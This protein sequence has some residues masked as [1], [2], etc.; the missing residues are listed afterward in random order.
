MVLPENA[1]WERLCFSALRRHQSHRLGR[2]RTP[3]PPTLFQEAF[4]ILSRCSQECLT[5]DPPEPTQAEASHAMPILSFRKHGLDPPL[6]LA[7]S[8]FLALPVLIR[9][10][11]RQ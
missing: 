11:A 4:E 5:V 10:A 8:L 3:P 2:K 6:S 9:P 7:Q 1:P